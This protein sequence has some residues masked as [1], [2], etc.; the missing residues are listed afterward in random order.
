MTEV[1]PIAYRRDTDLLSGIYAPEYIAFLARWVTNRKTKELELDMLP[2]RFSGP[3]RVA[4]E[5]AAMAFW[6]DQ[7]VQKQAKKERGRKLGLS[8]HSKR[9]QSETHDA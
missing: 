9:T 5:R 3:S 4:A 8:K 7:K 6:N 1:F 2:V